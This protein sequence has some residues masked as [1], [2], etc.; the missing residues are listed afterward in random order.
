[1]KAKLNFQ[2]TLVWLALIEARFTGRLPSLGRV[3]TKLELGGILEFQ[4]TKNQK[5]FTIGNS[6]CSGSEYNKQTEYSQTKTSIKDNAF[7]VFSFGKTLKYN[8]KI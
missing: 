4:A 3:Q 1:M 2:T 5:L 6:D 7:K 8:F